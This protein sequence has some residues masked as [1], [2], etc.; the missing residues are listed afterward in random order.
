MGLG[1]KAVRVHMFHKHAFPTPLELY[2]CL[3]STY[4]VHVGFVISVTGMDRMAEAIHT[5]RSYFGRKKTNQMFL[6]H[7]FRLL[8]QLKF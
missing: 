6:H 5:L 3:I 1:T 2:N 4:R 7:E 8:T